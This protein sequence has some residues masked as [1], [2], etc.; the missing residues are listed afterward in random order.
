MHAAVRHGLPYSL[1][2]S[3][4]AVQARRDL[5]SPPR[6]AQPRGRGAWTSGIFC[7]VEGVHVVRGYI[8]LHMFHSHVRAR[9]YDSANVG[10][11]EGQVY[12]GGC[13][14]RGTRAAGG[15]CLSV[16]RWATFQVR[17]GALRRGAAGWRLLAGQRATGSRRR[18]RSLVGGTETVGGKL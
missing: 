11:C 17:V 3:F 9:A 1:P 10:V 16:E 14:D 7:G 18:R 4:D 6:G 12:V 8:L 2:Y 5:R 15:L 13:G